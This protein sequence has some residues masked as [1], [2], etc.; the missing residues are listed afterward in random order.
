MPRL[1]FAVKA[2]EEIREHLKEVQSALVGSF[3]EVKYFPKFKAENIDNAHCTILFLGEVEEQLIEPLVSAVE[4]ELTHNPIS[5]FTIYTSRVG[6]FPGISKAKTIWLGLEPKLI[7]GRLHD[8]C[9]AAVKRTGIKLEGKENHFTPHL[10]LFRLREPFH[11]KGELFETLQSSSSKE[12]KGEIK[13]LIL[14]KSLLL[15]EGA[16]HEVVREFLFTS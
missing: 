16:K 8:L 1:F 12:S 3:S 14:F 11:F 2:P 15:P 4:S 13:S 9:T 6:V 10:T 5:P 7:L